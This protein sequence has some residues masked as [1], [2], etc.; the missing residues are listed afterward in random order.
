MSVIRSD[1]SIP[2]QLRS[3]TLGGHEDIS[4]NAECIFECVDRLSPD[5]SKKARSRRVS[6]RVKKS[7]N[8]EQA[9]SSVETREREESKWDEAMPA[10]GLILIHVVHVI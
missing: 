5:Y 8:G 4:S 1:A 9:D 3:Q 2:L 7:R 6:G 10:N